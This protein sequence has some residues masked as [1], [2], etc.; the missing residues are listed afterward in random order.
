MNSETKI[1]AFT[2]HREKPLKRYARFA[3]TEKFMRE[4]KN[5]VNKEISP[6]FYSLRNLD[7][8][9]TRAPAVAG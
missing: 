8:R 4:L 3:H 9:P 1:F 6:E 7:E 2:I 5:E